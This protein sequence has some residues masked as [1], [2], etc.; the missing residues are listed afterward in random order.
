[1]VAARHSIL[2]LHHLCMGG[3]EEM[4]VQKIPGR[5]GLERTLLLILY[6]VIPPP[7]PVLD[8]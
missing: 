3:I 7:I 2:H 5:L 1:M 8:T 4:V 6:L